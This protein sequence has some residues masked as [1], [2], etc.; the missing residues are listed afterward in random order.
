MNNINYNESSEQIIKAPQTDKPE[1]II[2][3]EILDNL[4]EQKISKVKSFDE[5]YE[6]LDNIGVIETRKGSITPPESFKKLI[7][8]IRE[9]KKPLNK[10]TFDAGLREKVEELLNI[11]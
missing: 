7:D 3:G 5:L 10:L 9:G 2:V 4:K 1:Y 6:V 8:E 11:H